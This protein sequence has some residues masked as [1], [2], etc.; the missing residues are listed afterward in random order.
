MAKKKESKKEKFLKQFKDYNGLIIVLGIC[1]YVVA[2]IV[3]GNMGEGSCTA[4]CMW[5]LGPLIAAWSIA[6]AVVFIVEIICFVN[7]A[8]YLKDEDKIKLVM[9]NVSVIGI[10]CLLFLLVFKPV[11]L[12]FCLGSGIVNIVMLI[13]SDV[14]FLGHIK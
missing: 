5:S 12:L 13:A 9:E 11:G 14:F 2:A 4:I 10:I 1:A 6:T 3:G 7:L 8:K